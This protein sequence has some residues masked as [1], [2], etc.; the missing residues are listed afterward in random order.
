[1]RVRRAENEKANKKNDYDAHDRKVKNCLMSYLPATRELCGFCQLRLRG[2]DK[3]VL[4]PGRKNSK[5]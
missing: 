4:K 5:S 3:S 2:W 1:M